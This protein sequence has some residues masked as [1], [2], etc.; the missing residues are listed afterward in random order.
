MDK[1]LHDK[2]AYLKPHG[3]CGTGFATN[4]TLLT[5]QRATNLIDTGLDIPLARAQKGS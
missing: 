2:V 1:R 5:E 4:C 3:F